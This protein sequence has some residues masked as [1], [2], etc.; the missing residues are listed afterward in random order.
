[1]DGYAV[2]IALKEKPINIPIVKDI[3]PGIKNSIQTPF[4]NIVEKIKG[5]GIFQN[6]FSK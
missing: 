4:N 2:V 1:M 3:Y 6:Y 5:L